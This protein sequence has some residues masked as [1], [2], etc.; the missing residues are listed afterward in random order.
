MYWKKIIA[1]IKPKLKTKE[2]LKQENERLKFLK[3]N[4]VLKQQI[5]NIKNKNS[6]ISQLGGIL[7]DNTNN[8]RRK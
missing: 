8:K 1:L 4:Y 5:K 7:N 6:L 3:D 2:E